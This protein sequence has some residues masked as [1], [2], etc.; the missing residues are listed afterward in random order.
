MEK[1]EL[2]GDEDYDNVG[3]D[4]PL[5]IGSL[6]EFEK[7]KELRIDSRALLGDWSDTESDI[8]DSDDDEEP[9]SRHS[10]LVDILPPSLEVLKL[11]SCEE[12]SLRLARELLEQRKDLVPVLRKFHLYFAFAGYDTTVAKELRD[13]YASNELEVLIVRL[14]QPWDAD[15]SMFMPTNV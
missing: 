3:I 1:F 6:K 15:Y 11:Y 2:R 10:K 13:A 8:I 9:P 5:P 4:E 12:G 14:R 7:L